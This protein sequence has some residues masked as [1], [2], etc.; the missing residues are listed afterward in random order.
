MKKTLL[1]L[2]LCVVELGVSAQTTKTQ[3]QLLM[4]SK[5]EQFLKEEGYMPTV[6]QQDQSVEF[7]KEGELFWIDVYGDEPYYLEF[8]RAG[9]GVTNADLDLVR[10][11]CNYA[12]L[13]HGCAKAYLTDTGIK[14]EV[15]IYVHSFDIFKK[16]FSSYLKTLINLSQ[17][18][19]DYYVNN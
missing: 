13:K 16:V 12:N 18:V 17:S 9:L 15:G 3:D 4:R 19:K 10:K 11:A 14:F 8:H 2:L 1:L 6:N 7:K 5:I